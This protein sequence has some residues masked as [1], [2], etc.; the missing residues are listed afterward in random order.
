[1]SPFLPLL[2]IVKNLLFQLEMGILGPLL[3]GPGMQHHIFTSQLSLSWSDLQEHHDAPLKEYYRYLLSDGSPP[4][5]KTQNSPI[6]NGSLTIFA[7][8]HWGPPNCSQLYTRLLI[9]HL[10]QSFHIYVRN[11]EH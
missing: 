1:M 8:T 6:L 2:R 11:W 3:G 10:L 9:G 7:F 4:L 5:L